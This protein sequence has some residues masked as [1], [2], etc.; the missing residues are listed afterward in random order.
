MRLTIT[1]SPTR[2][3]LGLPHDLPPPGAAML[4]FA[5]IQTSLL[6]M[7]VAAEIVVSRHKPGLRFGKASPSTADAGMASAASVNITT[8]KTWEDFFCISLSYR[9]NAQPRKLS[10]IVEAELSATW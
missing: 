4:S 1:S 8:V 9:M 6:V 3:T 10:P 7:P 5:L 2:S